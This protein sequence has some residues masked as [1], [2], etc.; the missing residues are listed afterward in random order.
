VNSEFLDS[1]CTAAG[2][3]HTVVPLM[4]VGEY[5]LEKSGVYRE[6]DAGPI[7]I[8]VPNRLPQG[9]SV[10]VPRTPTRAALTAR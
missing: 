10:Q 4:H 7:R 9:E 1:A 8:S 2:A 6:D 5:A 3:F